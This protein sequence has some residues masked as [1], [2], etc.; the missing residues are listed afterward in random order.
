MVLEASD[1][2]VLEALWEVLETSDVEEVLEAM[3][4]GLPEVWRLVG[5]TSLSPESAPES[6][7][8]IDHRFFSV[9]EFLSRRSKYSRHSLATLSSSWTISFSSI[10]FWGSEQSRESRAD[11]SKESRPPCVPESGVRRR[12]G[13]GRS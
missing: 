12:E 1:G 3:L 8:H 13:R 9:S 10:A 4:E 2:E 5:A 7:E 6:V 11:S